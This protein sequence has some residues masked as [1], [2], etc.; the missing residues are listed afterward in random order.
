[1]TL[2]KDDLKAIGDLLTSKFH[3]VDSRLNGI[4]R[5]LNGIDRR[6]NGIDGRLDRIDGR[7]NG[8]DEHLEVN[9]A[10]HQQMFSLLGQSFNYISRI[11]K[12]EDRVKNLKKQPYHSH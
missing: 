2:T 10:E 9:A 5:R 12:L 11:I 3:E 1:M 4:D 7:L 8:I 6:L